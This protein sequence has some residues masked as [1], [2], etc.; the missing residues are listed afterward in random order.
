MVGLFTEN[1]TGLNSIDF[2]HTR[3]INIRGSRKIEVE[4]VDDTELELFESILKCDHF[5]GVNFP[6]L[7]GRSFGM[8]F[9]NYYKSNGSWDYIG[10]D[11]SEV[12][13][14]HVAY[15]PKTYNPKSK[16]KGIEPVCL[17][18]DIY[19]NTTS[20][21]EVLNFIKIEG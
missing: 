13:L 11:G 16:R 10:G 1:Y 8:R 3:S 7:G 14:L 12:V 21:L 4:T 2:S 17:C 15:N 19:T 6:V 9:D 5:L 18:Y 20:L